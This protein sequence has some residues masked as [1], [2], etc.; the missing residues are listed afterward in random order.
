MEEL[1]IDTKK[2]Q[3]TAKLGYQAS[4]TIGGSDA[5]KFVPNVNASFQRKIADEFYLN[6]N[7]KSQV[8]NAENAS[9]SAES[10][11]ITIADRTDLFYIKEDGSIEHEIVFA[12]KPASNV[13]ELEIK[14]TE[15]LSF[16]QVP[17]LTQDRIDRG[18]RQKEDIDYSYSIFCDKQHGVYHYGKIGSIKRPYVIDN[19]GKKTWCDHTVSVKGGSGSWTIEIPEEI[20]ANESLYPLT[21]G[22]NVGYTDSPAGIFGLAGRCNVSEITTPSDWS[23]LTSFHL[24]VDDANL[25]SREIG[26]GIYDDD[27]GPN[28]LLTDYA[29]TYNAAWDNASA[30]TPQDISMGLPPNSETLDPSTKYWAGAACENSATDFGYDVYPGRYIYY[31][32]SLTASPEPDSIFT[33]DNSSSDYIICC[34]FEYSASAGTTEEGETAVT[35]TGSLSIS[36]S[37]GRSMAA[38]SAAASEAEISSSSQRSTAP[39]TAATSTASAIASGMRSA[40]LACSAQSQFEVIGSAEETGT[41]IMAISAPSI[42]SRTVKRT[43]V[44]KTVRRT[45][46]II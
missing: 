23:A 26:I 12:K 11:S 30:D 18:W 13:V 6:I 7:A 33:V 9:L 17:P 40:D 14:C 16:S 43:L 3:A 45:I 41:G 32:L 5:S 10:T 34:Y 2:L 24:W 38:Q 39:S 19:D 46:H 42:I 21:I 22:P 1:T 4:I 35:C 36:G 20:W 37:G 28:A 31:D 8:V 44:S 25:D 27:S 29:V 15:F